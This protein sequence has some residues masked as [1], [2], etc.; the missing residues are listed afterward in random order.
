MLQF[1]VNCFTTFVL[2]AALLSSHVYSQSAAG[3]PNKQV[4]FILTQAP[5]GANDITGRAIAQKLTEMLKVPFIVD[6]RPGAGGNIA[7]Q[8]VAKAP[9][10]GYTLLL[11]LGNTIVINPYLYKSTGFDAQKDF[12]PVAPIV[13][14]P[15]VLVTNPAFPPK[16]IKELITYAQ[17]R[18]G[19]LFYG[20]AGNGTPNHLLFDLFKYL[21]KTNIVHVP[22]KGAAASAM[23]TVSGQVPMNF[24]SLPLALPLIKDGRLRALGITSVT[25]S[26]LAPEIPPIADTVPGFNPDMWVGILAPAG[27]PKEIVNKLHSDIQKAINSKDFRDSMTEKGLDIAPTSSPADFTKMIQVESLRWKKII[28]ES[29]ATID[30]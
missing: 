29:G 28:A 3:Y 25:R 21:T 4:T 9:K 7:A 22:Y 27:T 1:L 24:S 13:R 12:E 14:A 30:E 11:A 6:N 19:E 20:S 2:S 8:Y 16:T 23:D 26:P 15:Y 17:A 18:P 10:D 5:G